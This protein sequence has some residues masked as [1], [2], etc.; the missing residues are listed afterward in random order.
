MR[1]CILFIPRSGSQY[2]EEI[3]GSNFKSV[4]RFGELFIY[5]R[6]V[7]AAIKLLDSTDS[8]NITVRLS[9][10]STIS[11]HFTEIIDCLKRNNFTFLVLRREVSDTLLSFAYASESNVWAKRDSSALNKVTIHDPSAM[12]WIY[13]EIKMFDKRIEEMKVDYQ[14]VH[15]ETMV[16][17]LEKIFNKKMDLSDTYIIKQLGNTPYNYI[18]NSTAV[19]SFIESLRKS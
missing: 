10:V 2:L 15:Y 9:V 16:Q 17:D 4:L 8:A 12:V 7:P 6:Q 18:E 1:I 11:P 3:I 5:P 14:T 13:N 19:S